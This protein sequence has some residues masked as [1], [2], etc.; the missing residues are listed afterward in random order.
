MDRGVPGGLDGDAIDHPPIPSAPSLPSDPA[1]APIGRD[2]GNPDPE[3]VKQA[4]VRKVVPIGDPE[5]PESR[6]PNW[7]T[8]PIVVDK[9]SGLRFKWI[10]GKKIFIERYEE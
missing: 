4:K 7:H 8:R 1:P 9:E 10:K 3:V 5:I 2:A 6:N